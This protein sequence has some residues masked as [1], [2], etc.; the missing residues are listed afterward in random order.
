MPDDPL[1]A[2][3]EAVLRGETA[4]VYFH[5]TKEILAAADD[6]S[7]CDDGG[8]RGAGRGCSA[9]CGKRGR[10]SNGSARPKR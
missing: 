3:T 4:D 1:F 2:P 7:D 9:E 5:R 6:Q 10:C 8:L